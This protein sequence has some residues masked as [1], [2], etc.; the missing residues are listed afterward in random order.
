MA[1]NRHR[2]GMFVCIGMLALGALMYFGLE[3]ALRQLHQ[4]PDVPAGI[5]SGGIRVW[6]A[7]IK[8]DPQAMKIA[9]DAMSS[10]GAEFFL[11]QGMPLNDLDATAR[12]LGMNGPENPPTFS[13]SENAELSAR[14][15]GNAILSRQTL[16]EGRTIP[17]AGGGSM[18]VWGWMIIDGKRF[19][20]ASVQ[21]QAGPGP[22]NEIAREDEMKHLRADWLARDQPP[23]IAAFA[24]VAGAD[25]DALARVLA[26]FSELHVG[27]DLPQPTTASATQS[28]AGPDLIGWTAPWS[29]ATLESAANGVQEFKLR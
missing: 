20:L 29:G 26:S 1:A 7:D 25:R 10:G 5:P 12:N 22:L 11:A 17:N 9:G 13:A 15:W 24:P 23:M 2:S 18:G 6:V 8:N 19:L 27:A 3:L 4:V 14:I 28:A 16:F 21:F